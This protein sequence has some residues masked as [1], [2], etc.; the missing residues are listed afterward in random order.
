MADVK[1][2]AVVSTTDLT[3]QA[4]QGVLGVVY[5]EAA[6][7][8]KDIE[9]ATNTIAS[10]D[11]SLFSASTLSQ[12]PAKELLALRKALHAERMDKVNYLRKL[13]LDVHVPNTDD[14]KAA[15]AERIAALPQSVVE[16]ILDKVET[17]M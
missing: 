6:Q 13:Y 14:K 4:Q 5:N 12:L 1:D 16:D 3:P 15:L 7:F 2:L 10:I 11:A 17:E 8:K 9:E